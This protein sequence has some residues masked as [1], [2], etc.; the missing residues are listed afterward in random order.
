MIDE[1]ILFEVLDKWNCWNKELYIGVERPKYI[2]ELLKCVERKEILVLKGIRR[3]GKSTIMKQLMQSLIKEGK[4]KEQLLYLYLED[5]N[6]ARYHSIELFDKVLDVY[7]K[8]INP[9]KKIY[10]FIDE[11]QLINGW[12]KWVRTKYDLMED[13][14]FIVSGSCASLIS[15]EFSTSL[16]GRNLSFIIKPL[17]FEEFLQFKKIN[18]RSIKEEE[19]IEEYLEFG[20]FPEVV[21]ENNAE[22]KQKLLEQYFEDI[23]HKDIIERYKIR[24]SK[25]IHLLAKYL[26][27]NACQK[28]SHNKL[29]K[30]FG[31]SVDTVITYVSYMIDAF[32]INEVT[33]FSYS[34][35]I[36]HDVLKLSKIYVIDNGFINIANIEF[37]ENLGKKHEN[38]VCI[39]LLESFKEI[40][41]WSEKNEVDFVAGNTAINVVSSKIIPEREYAGLKEISE[42]FKQIKNKVLVTK[43]TKGKKREINLIPLKEFLL[44]IKY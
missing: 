32:L 44:N 3:C 7:R 35:R 11:I 20:G 33:Y 8:K 17:S 4:S 6:L 25:Q 16:T 13:I 31:L 29:A 9:D 15:R 1:N 37:T 24:N 18:N 2:S 42:K 38:A 43:S 12:E 19:F 22:L 27:A 23:I 28:I 41:Y 5:F 40:S 30:S 14:K 34:V 36:K 21:L 39:K 10:F 26:S